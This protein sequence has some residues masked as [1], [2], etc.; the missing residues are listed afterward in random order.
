MA[1]V[2]TL[3]NLST[4][5]AQLDLLLAGYQ[6]KLDTQTAY[7]T[8]GS[9]TKVPQ[10]TTNSLGQV[11]AITEVAITD[12]NDNQKINRNGYAAVCER[13]K[14]ACSHAGSGGMSLAT[15]I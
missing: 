15:V 9:A 11:T 3:D 2:I 14:M 7:T 1:K 10:I 6:T 4:F 5:K 8:K 12:N 13:S